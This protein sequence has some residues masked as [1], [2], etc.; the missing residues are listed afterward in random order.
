MF[1]WQTNN[2][3]YL[4]GNYSSVAKQFLRCALHQLVNNKI[5]FHLFQ[6]NF[7]SSDLLEALAISLN[8]FNE[9][10]SV[11][12]LRQIINVNLKLSLSLFIKKQK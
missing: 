1:A 7:E 3:F 4:P 8:D 12:A 6:H 5:F 10:T 9:L 11:A 2:N